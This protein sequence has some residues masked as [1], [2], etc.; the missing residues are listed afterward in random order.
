MVLLFV[1]KQDLQDH[2]KGLISV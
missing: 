2:F 1:L